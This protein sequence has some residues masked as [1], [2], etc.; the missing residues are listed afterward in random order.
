MAENHFAVIGHPIAHTMSPFI[1]E[2]LFAL[3]GKA[4]RYGV[5][6]IAPEE[7]PGRMELLRTLIGFNITIPHKQSIIPLLD[8][9]NEKSEFFHS[10]NTVKNTDGRLTGFTTDG[11]GFCKALK[12]GGAFL[13]GRTVVLGAGGAGR[14][15][16]FEAILAGSSVTVAVRPH[17]L[18]AAEKLCA[19]IRA[20]TAGAQADFC[21][22]EDIG[23]KIDLLANATPVGMFPRTGECPVPEETIRK[24]DCVFDAVYNPDQTLLIRTARKNGVRA[25]GGMSMLVWQAAAAHEIW[26]GASFDAGDIQALCADAVAEMKRKFGNIVLCGYMGSGKTCVGNRLARITGRTFVDMDRYIEQKEGVTVA[27]IFSSRGEAAFRAMERAAA[28]E[29]SLKSGLII[30]TG[31]GALMDPE[32]TAALKGNGVIVL[33]DASVEAIRQRLSGDSTRPLLSGPGREETMSRLYSERT[34]RYRAAADFTVDA[35]G[36]VE[37]VAE[38]IR[39]TVKI[40]LIPNE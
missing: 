11:T 3:S 4:G 35:D 14:V 34:D 12:A 13:D 37:T 23:G 5:L 19:D 17:G 15:L 36:G 29:L 21:L 2:R 1:H 22:M 9:L 24:A 7:L 33:L 38:K 6:D 10:V 27:E 20:K 40:P 28:K 32:N 39:E 30:A 31:G 18:A 8:G 26:Y 16:A 25:V